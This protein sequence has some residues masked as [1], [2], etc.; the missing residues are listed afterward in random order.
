MADSLIEASSS[1]TTPP[2]LEEPSAFNSRAK[3]FIGMAVLLTALGY[4]AFLAFESATVYYY[5]VSEIQEIGPN[6]T[7]GLVRVNGKLIPE[8]FHRGDGS[9]VAEFNVTDG[10]RTLSATHSGVLPD[11]F[12]N[13]HSELILEGTYGVDGVFYSEN[14]I[15]KCP[16]K[17]VAAADG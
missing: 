10:D 2:T 12:F 14:V 5:T 9:I 6:E 17:Y 16:S 13:E 11:L 15:V 8:S 4:F 1:E 7:G 3:V